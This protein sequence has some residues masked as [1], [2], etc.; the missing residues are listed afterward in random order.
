MATGFHSIV[1]KCHSAWIF[2]VG[3]SLFYRRFLPAPV[4]IQANPHRYQERQGLV[5]EHI[6][7]IVGG[8]E[9][10]DNEQVVQDNGD[11]GPDYTDLDK[12]QKGEV[13]FTEP[14]PRYND[15][16]RREDGSND[17]PHRVNKRS[18]EENEGSDVPEQPEQR[19]ESHGVF[20]PVLHGEMSRRRYFYGLWN[21]LPQNHPFVPAIMTGNQIR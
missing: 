2:F 1:M 15:G 20:D 6:C 17:P 21:I 7:F 9:Q 4:Q 18:E 10:L 5:H 12:I 19:A 14:Q 8:L 13:S 11:N 16:N 3:L